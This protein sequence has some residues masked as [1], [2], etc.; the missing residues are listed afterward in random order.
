MVATPSYKDTVKLM[1]SKY[2]GG[3][4]QTL[5]IQTGGLCGDCG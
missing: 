3:W 5:Q 4:C 1:T 2:Y